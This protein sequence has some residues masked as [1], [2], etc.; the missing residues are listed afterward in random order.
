MINQERSRPVDKQLGCAYKYSV[1]VLLRGSGE[2]VPQSWENQKGLLKRGRVLEKKRSELK[3]DRRV[4]G[5][6]SR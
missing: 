3:K 1:D 6:C 4:E 5:R 2:N